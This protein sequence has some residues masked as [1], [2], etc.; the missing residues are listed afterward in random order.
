M[1]PSASTSTATA[2]TSGAKSSTSNSTA[3]KSGSTSAGAGAKRAGSSTAASRQA[4]VT[5]GY[6]SSPALNGSDYDSPSGSTS[7]RASSSQPAPM[8]LSALEVLIHNAV[9]ASPKRQILQS[10]LR[11]IK[12]IPDDMARVGDVVNG[13]VRKSLMSMGKNHAGD[14]VFKAIPK[15]EARELAAMDPED[16]MVYDHIQQAH[17]QGIWTRSLKQKTGL[18]QNVI[19]RAIK[20]LEQKRLIKNV[21]S[22]KYPTR[23]IYML[24][25]VTPSLDVTGGPWYA[26]N[27]LDVEFINTLQTLAKQYIRKKSF[28]DGRPELV[29]P[30]AHI[31]YLPTAADILRYLTEKDVLRGV[32][33]DIEHIEAILNVLVWDGEIERLWA[34]RYSEDDESN[35]E[36]EDDDTYMNG[37]GRKRK[38]AAGSSGRAT[39][40]RRQRSDSE[41]ID[42][43]SQEESDYVGNGRKR[44]PKQESDEDDSA[45]EAARRE[46][47]SADEDYLPPPLASR[48]NGTSRVNKKHRRPGPEGH[49]RYW[50][51]RTCLTALP[52]GQTKDEEGMTV[53]TFP[54][55]YDVGLTQT[56]CG[57]CPVAEFCRN[58]GQ[59]KVLP[60]PGEKDLLA[61]H[62]SVETGAP[63]VS[64]NEVSTVKAKKIVRRRY[65]DLLKMKVPAGGGLL[66]DADGMW[67]GSTKI[68][69]TPI[70]PVNPA[71]CLYYA[72]WF[73][74]EFEW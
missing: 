56:P 10:S 29:W 33:L 40:R 17:N 16:R 25:S 11:N 45:D 39:K 69:G 24:A 36:E 64:L 1:P 52:S 68:G 18:H 62:P 23:K 48:Q 35:G 42:E 20:T 15:Q 46:E 57:V 50:V 43:D 61:K 47:Q 30:L 49:E 6:R 44:R 71:G 34:R 13:L 32:E 54:A 72:Q 53:Q 8:R 67:K 22:V 31:P 63:V 4:S 70:A 9:L 14:L 38:N 73:G 28:P 12:G 3:R 55:L 66:E 58:R 59:P 51:Y 19:S 60:L 65:D 21:K 5:N 2:S 41:A 37:T 26:G 74:E 7:M 27:D